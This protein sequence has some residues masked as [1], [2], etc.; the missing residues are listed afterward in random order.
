MRARNPAALPSPQGVDVLKSKVATHYVPSAALPELEAA[1]KGLGAGADAGS[2]RELLDDF[3]ARTPL[4]EGQLAQQ[5]QDIDSVFLNPG[6]VE[7]VHEA[8]RKHP[9]QAWAAEVLD[10]INKCENGGFVVI[11]RR[12]P[13]RGAGF[14]MASCRTRGSVDRPEDLA[15]PRTCAMTPPLTSDYASPETAD[16]PPVSVPLPQAACFPREPFPLKTPLPPPH[17]HH[18]KTKNSAGARPSARS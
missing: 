7:A 13:V 4:P 9:N 17:H 11:W 15:T 10:Q 16:L 18:H 5:R 1:L 14:W 8:L 6:S 12:G 2:V 3:Q